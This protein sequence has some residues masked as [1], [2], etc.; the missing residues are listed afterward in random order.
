[1]KGT[2]SHNTRPHVESTF[3]TIIIY[4]T[5]E[6]REDLCKWIKS[7]RMYKLASNIDPADFQTGPNHMT[8]NYRWEFR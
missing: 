3:N 2:V 5:P 4:W 6:L 7:K 1:M 8:K